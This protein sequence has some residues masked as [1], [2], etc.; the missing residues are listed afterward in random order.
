MIPPPTHTWQAPIVEDMVQEGRVGP[1]EAIVTGPG[2]AVLF[3]GWLSLGEELNLGE[4]V[5][6]HIH[7][8]RSHSEGQ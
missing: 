4:A 6:C 3:Y 8:I 2:W 1:M 7:I 5:R